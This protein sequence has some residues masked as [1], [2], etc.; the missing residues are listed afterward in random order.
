MA[1]AV[2]DSNLVWQKVKNAL[3]SL[4][5]SEMAKDVFKRLKLDLATVKGNPKLQ[6]VFVSAADMVT[7]GGYCP[8]VDSCRIYG[9]YFKGARTSGTTAAFLSINDAADNSATTGTVLTAKFKEAGEEFVAASKFG[10]GC[11]T[12]VTVACATTVGGATESN[13][14][15]AANGFVIIAD[16]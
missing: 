14:A 6:F 8:D 7:N 13:A 1:I 16:E 2:E 10:W 12:D 15:D 3:E 4:G 9:A 5:A 11:A